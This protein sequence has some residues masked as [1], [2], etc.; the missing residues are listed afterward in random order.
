M[1]IAP[2][3]NAR[4]VDARKIRAEENARYDLGMKIAFAKLLDATV[5]RKVE[6]FFEKCNAIIREISVNR[7]SKRDESH[8]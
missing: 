6:F 1:I 3:A 2:R 4:R 7:D 8:V 5:V